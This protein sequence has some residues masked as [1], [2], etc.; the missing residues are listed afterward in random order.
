[1]EGIRQLDEWRALSGRLPAPGAKVAVGIPLAAPLRALAPE[2][3]DAFQLALEGGTFQALLDRAAASDAEV[4]GRLLRLA[5]KGY[6]KVVG[7]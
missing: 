3:L 6:L 1:M 2:D 4:A 5:E 7:P